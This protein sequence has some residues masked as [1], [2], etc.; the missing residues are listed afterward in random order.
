MAARKHRKINSKGET[1]VEAL[2]SLTILSLA[3]LSMTYMITLSN[4]LN[5]RTKE[6]N[7]NIYAQASDIEQNT[8]LTDVSSG[9]ITIR[10]NNTDIDVPVASQRSESLFIF[11]P[12][13]ETP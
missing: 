7:A 11:A 1:L 8:N 13:K 4:T 5:A 6:R 9:K 12:T 2:V 10:I 3:V